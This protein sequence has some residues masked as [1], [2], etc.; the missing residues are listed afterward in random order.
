VND[1]GERYLWER[2]GPPD[3]LVAELERRL[4]VFRHRGE[5]SVEAAPTTAAG[6]TPARAG[7]SAARAGGATHLRL[8]AAAAALAVALGGWWLVRRAPAG[9]EWRVEAVAG[10][11]RLASRELRGEAA[12]RPGEA[13]ETGAGDR[14]RIH[15]AGV[16][17][18]ELAPGSRLRLVR[19][20]PGAHR[21]ALERGALLALIVA[22]PQVFQVATP[23]TT[24]VDLGCMFALDVL[25]DGGE[26]VRVEAGWVALLAA[27]REVFVPA[28]AVVETAA[29]RPPGA[30]V[31]LAA[32]AELRRALRR[33]E[34]AQAGAARDGDLATVLAL[35]GPDDAL[36]LWHLL[37]VTGGTAQGRVFDRLAELAPPPASVTRD[38]VVLGDRA[39]LDAWWEALGLGDAAWW[40]RWRVELPAGPSDGRLR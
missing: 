35:A 1:D 3:P 40:R 37:S 15:F 38:G 14:A 33:W 20:R 9:G 22:P 6:T 30:P 19:S 16:G 10:A 17:E 4:A 24:V 5:P 27:G 34:R 31:R 28:G 18:V 2:E 13:L 23:R 29:G 7:S 26:R 12:L 32:P 36:T 11:P 39:Q 25:P 21:L 8:A